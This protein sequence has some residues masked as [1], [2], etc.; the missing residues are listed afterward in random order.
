M[1]FRLRPHHLICNLCFQGKGYNATF[2]ENFQKIHQALGNELHQIKITKGVDDI[3]QCCPK[4]QKDHC[5]DEAKVAKL[6]RIYLEILQLQYAETI[7]LA[8]AK[9][10]IKKMLSLQ[11]FH[12]ACAECS[13]KTAGICEK[14]IRDLVR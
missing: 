5:Q 11:A 3:C 8:Q 2:I 12:N 6:D 14:V 1:L 9:N 4:K 10:K 13:W 7:T